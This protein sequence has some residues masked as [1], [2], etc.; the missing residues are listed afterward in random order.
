MREYQQ[1]LE[2]NPGHAGAL[3]NLAMIHR[4]AERPAEEESL[5]R[6]VLEIDPEHALA[7]LFLARIYL[8]R[9]ER[10]REAVVMVEGAIEEPLE[11]DE[12]VLGYFLLADLYNRLGDP[13][14]ANEYARRGQLLMSQ[15]R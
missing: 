7:N 2:A 11:T 8:R 5:L 12:L 13:R 4:V 15:Q 1:E 9:N 6:Q 14:R 10:Y 3:F